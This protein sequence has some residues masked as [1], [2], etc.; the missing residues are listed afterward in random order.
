M[1]RFAL[2]AAGFASAAIAGA[3]VA[4]VTVN[5]D[6][7]MVYGGDGV[8]FDL[9]GYTGTMTGMTVVANFYNAASSSSWASDMLVAVSNGTSGVSA[10]GYNMGFGFT[11]LGG[12]SWSYEFGSYSSYKSASFDM[13]GNSGSLYVVNGWTGT[14][15][16]AAWSGSVTLHGLTAV[17]APG[18]LALLGLAGL[19][20]RR[21]R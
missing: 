19:V 18:A 15:N 11:D 10:G 12:F 3:S 17:P 6:T 21:R 9:S 16:F 8:S 20:G 13:T 7:G 4:D 2:T 14:T 5:Y 1:K